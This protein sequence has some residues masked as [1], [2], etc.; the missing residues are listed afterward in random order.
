MPESLVKMR[1]DLENLKKLES[2]SRKSYQ[3]FKDLRDKS[4]N[5]STLEVPKK[6][7]SSS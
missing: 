7:N 6:T 2:N 4:P 5:H 3:L 1:K